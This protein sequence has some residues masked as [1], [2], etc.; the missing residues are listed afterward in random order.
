MLA[1]VGRV[2]VRQRRVRDHSDVV[3]E[4]PVHEFLLL[5]VRVG[6]KFVGE[7]A[8]LA[9]AQDRVELT[10]REVGDA[11]VACEIGTDERFHRPPGVQ[12][13]GVLVDDRAAGGGVGQ[14]CHGPVH[15]VQVKIGDR[16]VGEGFVQCR[17]DEFGSV[18]RVP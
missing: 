11:N 18:G 14:E 4:V 2:H 8:D 3:F 7:W 16:E 5:E 15:E 12:E 9:A 6:F 1:I 10:G 13:G 17:G